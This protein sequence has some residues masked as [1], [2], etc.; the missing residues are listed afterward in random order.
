MRERSITAIPKPVVLLVVV[1]LLIQILWHSAQPAYRAEAE[2][3]T[4]SPSESSLQLLSL[5]DPVFLAKML[6][7]WLQAFDNQP[8]VSIPF[9][10]LDYD[11]LETWLSSILQLDPGGQYPLLAASRLYAMVPDEEKQR[12]MLEF[13]YQQFL[14]DPANRWPWLA[15]AVIV[16]KYRLKDLPLALKFSRVIADKSYSNEIPSWA[17]Q[18]QLTVL[19][20]MGELESA[21]F[22]I[23]GLL[24]SGKITDPKEIEFLNLRLRELS[25]NLNQNR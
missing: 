23:G 17:S 1:S 5:G 25:N 7:L 14:I 24:K 13:V 6:M 22:L 4:A 2:D 18:M 10:D 12:Q 3:L 11:K 8:G 9:K 15:H 20:D 21:Q 19:E 16:A